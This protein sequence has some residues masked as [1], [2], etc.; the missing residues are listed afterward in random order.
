MQ[1]ID[2]GHRKVQSGSLEYNEAILYVPSVC[3][4]LFKKITSHILP[5]RRVISARTAF[6]I[7]KREGV[8][9]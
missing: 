8:R 5:T 1:S 3:V 4:L 9:Y 2:D 7:S 6:A